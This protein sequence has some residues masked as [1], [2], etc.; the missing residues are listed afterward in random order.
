MNAIPLWRRMAEHISRGIVLR[1][2]LPRDFGSAEIRVTPEAG[3][4]YWRYNL[5]KADP[6]LFQMARELV[7]EGDVVWDI[8]SNVGLFA[9]AAAA[10]AGPSG[11]VIAVEPDL[12]LSS[13]I[14]LSARSQS[15]SRATV[16][17][18][19]AA[20]S[21]QNGLARLQIAARS[22]SANHLEGVASEVSGGV[23]TREL[24]ATF[25]LDSLLDHLPHPNVLKIDVEGM[26]HRVL[27]GSTRLLR[28]VRPR[29]WCEVWSRNQPE[30]T[31]LLHA[32]QYKIFPANV[33]KALPGEVL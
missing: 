8:G 16:S 27:Q 7:Q 30:A 18:L 28:S 19:A 22:R 5:L 15:R 14:S 29:I 32:A 6:L 21:D 11:H 13:L 10:L 17:V 26:E 1:R 31:R 2:R 9:F 3:L 33:P 23:R 25:T 20:I 4:K 12:W 24:T